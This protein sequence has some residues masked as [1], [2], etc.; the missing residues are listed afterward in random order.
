MPKIDVEQFNNWIDSL[1]CYDEDAF[2]IKAAI[3]DFVEKTENAEQNDQ[4]LKA[5]AGK[6]QPTLVPME[7]IEAVAQ[8]MMFGLKK[9][10]K[11]NSWRQVNARRYEDALWRHMMRY[12]RDPN[13][14]DAESGLPHMYHVATNAAFLIALG[15]HKGVE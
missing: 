10:G 13:G 5:D 11:E 8:V 15:P 14:V 12:T 4:E 6:I 2:W 1:A 3:K 9:Y 7:L